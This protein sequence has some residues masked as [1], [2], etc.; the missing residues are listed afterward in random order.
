MFVVGLRVHFRID[1]RGREPIKK[2]INACIY[3]VTDGEKSVNEA[4]ER[5]RSQIAHIGHLHRLRTTESTGGR[6][7]HNAG[8]LSR[9]ATAGPPVAA[10]QPGRIVDILK[11]LVE[12]DRGVGSRRHTQQHH[13]EHTCAHMFHVV[14][15]HCTA[16]KEVRPVFP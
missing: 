6:D 14:F 2:E 10:A 11:P 12:I 1:I 5:G 4:G 15:H 9:R 7:F 3:R 8:V 16:P 13:T